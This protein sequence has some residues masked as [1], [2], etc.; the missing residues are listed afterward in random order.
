MKIPSRPSHLRAPFKARIPTAT[1][2]GL[3][4]LASLVHAADDRWTGATNGNWNVDSNWVTAAPGATTGVNNADT[5]TFDTAPANTSIT[6]DAGRNIRNITF[7]GDAGSYTFGGGTLQL[8]SG[9]TLLMTANVADGVTQTFNNALSLNGNYDIRNLDDGTARFVFA[10]GITAATKSTLYFYTY[11]TTATTTLNTISGVMADGAG[12]LSVSFGNYSS[13]NGRGRYEITGNNTYSGTTTINFRGGAA[14][15][16]GELITSG[17]HDSDGAVNLS[18]GTLTLNNTANGGISRGLLSMGAGSYLR[19]NKAGAGTLSNNLQTS[20]SV[21]ITGDHDITI[22]GTFTNGAADDRS[23]TNTIVSGQKLTLNGNVYL[24]NASATGRNWAIRGTGE[25]LIN[26]DVS[27]FSGGK[28]A[29]ASGINFSPSG[30]GPRKLT[31]AG[32]NTYS[33]D[34]TLGGGESTVFILAETG[35]MTFYIGENG[36][37][38]MVTGSATAEF[39]GS[40]NFDVSEADF[41]EGNSWNIVDIATVIESFT[42]SFSV[43]GFT[44]SGTVWSDGNGFS[45]DTSTGVLSYSAVPEPSTYALFAALA[46]L[47][48]AVKRRKRQSI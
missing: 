48:V 14:G 25:T 7:D 11:D 29:A 40:F 8:A 9:G 1:A 4:A 44:R 2:L 38:N 20:N 39:N 24:S 41:T 10:G 12:A 37:N 34:T 21:N 19:A 42:S 23:L 18:R 31:L 28:G 17:T 15:V 35:S 22:N 30:T 3:L 26:G 6:I 27:D 32:A 5:A 13:G 43:T 46:G 36:E 47:L 33:G 16:N 45:F